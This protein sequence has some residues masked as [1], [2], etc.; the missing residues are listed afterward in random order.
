MAV[1][2]NDPKQMMTNAINIAKKCLT[3]L[4]VPSSNSGAQVGG[5]AGTIAL[6]SGSPW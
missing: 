6:R 5:I 4:N 2:V 3:V 1:E